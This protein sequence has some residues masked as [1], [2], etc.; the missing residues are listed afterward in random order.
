MA[1]FNCYVSSPEGI[2]YYKLEHGTEVATSISS[3][4]V[5]LEMI[6]GLWPWVKI[7]YSEDR[8]G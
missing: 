5:S 1:I 4:A 3:A 2:N 6:G 7:G 8:R